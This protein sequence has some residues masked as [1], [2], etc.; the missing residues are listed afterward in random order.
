VVKTINIGPEDDKKEIKIGASLQTE[1]KRP[2]IMYLTVLE[3]SMGCV[4]GQHDESGRKEHAIYYL[5]KSLPT[6]NKDTH[7]SRKLA[8]LWD[9]LLAD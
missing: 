6:V 7:C 4:L 5:S 8:A 1:R 3:R 9:G 2:L